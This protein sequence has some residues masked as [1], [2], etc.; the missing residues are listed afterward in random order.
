MITRINESKTLTKH[1]ITNHGNVNVNLMVES[2]IQIKSGMTTN[3]DVCV[4]NVI[5]GK[6]IYLESCYMLL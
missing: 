1:D 3:V 6:K 2:V 4:K 5:Y